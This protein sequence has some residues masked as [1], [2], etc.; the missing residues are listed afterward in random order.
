LT[1]PNDNRRTVLDRAIEAISP[2]W[3]AR[4][5]F[6]RAQLAEVRQFSA[7]YRGGIATRTG[8]SFSTSVSYNRGTAADRR[9]LASMRDRAR[10]VYRENPIGKSILNTET[11][12][13]IADG[14]TL[15][16]K[17]SSPD[18]NKEVEERWDLWMEYADIR[19]MFCGSDLQRQAY[20]SPRRDG[21][22]GI[23]LVDRGTLGNSRLQ[24]IPGDLIK[25]PDGMYGDRNVVDGI[26]VDDATRPVA[27][28][29][30]DTDE[31]G[32]RQWA[33]V[34]A[35][36]FIYLCPDLDD[37]LAVRGPTCFSTV[38]GELDGLDGYKDA[39][40]T[41][42]RLGAMIGLIFKESKPAASFNGLPSLTNSRGEQQKA[43]TLEN[44]TAR[45][46]GKDDDVVQVNAQQPMQQTPEFIR[47]QL[48]LIGIPFDMPLE[49]IAKDMS[50][51]NFA[52]AR[53]GLLQYY[54]ACRVKQERFV[55]RCLDRIYF[56]WLSRERKKQV[57]GVDGAFVTEF[58]ADYGKHKFLP[59]A[60]DYTDPVSEAQADQLQIDMGTKSPQSVAAERGRDWEEIQVELQAARALQK[61]K[62][63][64]IIHST[65]TR[66]P[67]AQVPKPVPQQEQ[68]PQDDTADET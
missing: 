26:E 55:R 45:Y 58:P 22:G 5:E 2:A 61:L 68:Q 43:L 23:V 4:R 33:R 7:S 10:R 40:I 63:L 46:I 35:S 65:M 57:A 30:L 25:T 13:V 60:W 64:P 56:W 37:D 50:T 6:G 54:R 31:W 62:D 15:Q 27:F 44:G 28:H 38:F 14:F 29:I 39:V 53:I 48:R 8:T 18:F 42:A 32:K 66:D 19:Q 1:K 34:P 12:N 51:V 20:R 16:A 67:L 36:N 52:S 59:R 21:D 11:D 41:A 9:S 3:A 24:F 47:T 49:L 17:T